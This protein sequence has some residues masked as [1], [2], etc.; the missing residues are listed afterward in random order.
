[1]P[2]RSGAKALGA[3][4]HWLAG[5]A[6]EAGGSGIGTTHVGGG[7]DVA[8][9]MATLAGLAAGSGALPLG[10]RSQAASCTEPM[11]SMQ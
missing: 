9:R 5:L 11:M 8:A 3:T 7:A 2:R 1:M 6:A 4:G 10:L